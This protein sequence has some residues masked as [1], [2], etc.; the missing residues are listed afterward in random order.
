MVER[1]ML[2]RLIRV[3]EEHAGE[4]AED[5]RQ[6]LLRNPRTSSYQVLDD[7]VLYV[8]IFELYSHLGNWLLTDTEKG[9]VP[10][11]YSS[12]GER[13]FKEGFALHEI[14]QALITTRRHVRDTIAEKGI[15]GTAKEL[16][17]V[18]DLITVLHRFFDMAIYYSIVGYYR[19]LGMEVERIKIRK[20][21]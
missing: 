13:W 11:Y 17:T 19:P 14:V 4:M 1:S 6:R 16:D 5:L 20:E 2:E 21:L 10:A 3:I 15:T 9:E 18:I 12:L 7:K 8:N